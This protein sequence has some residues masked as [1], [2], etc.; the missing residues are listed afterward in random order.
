MIDSQIFY[1]SKSTNQHTL[2]KFKQNQPKKIKNKIATKKK[3]KK[4]F[5]K[6]KMKDWT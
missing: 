4:D 1:L 3:I 5:S 2:I 6:I